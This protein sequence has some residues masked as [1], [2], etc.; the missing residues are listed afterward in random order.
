MSRIQPLLILRTSLFL[1][2]GKQGDCAS[3]P[4]SKK[5]LP[6]EP[7]QHLRR[8]L[9]GLRGQKAYLGLAEQV[10][11]VLQVSADGEQDIRSAQEFI[12][13][14]I[15]GGLYVEKYLNTYRQ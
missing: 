10:D 3:P 2:N 14:L 9:E 4:R 5:P 8:L 7:C 13:Y 12:H 11:R 6:S 1:R 15:C